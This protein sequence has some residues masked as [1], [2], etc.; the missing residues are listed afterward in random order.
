MILNEYNYN[1]SDTVA[2]ITDSNAP[3]DNST[4]S[5]DGADR[6]TSVSK[7]ADPQSFTRDDVGNRTGHTRYGETMSVSYTGGANTV[8]SRQ[9]SQSTT[10]YGYDAL[11]NLAQMTEG[12]VVHAYGYDG[13]NRQG[14]YYRDAE[15]QGDYRYNGPNQ[16]VWK[17]AEEAGGHFIYGPSGELLCDDNHTGISGFGPT[18]YYWAFGQLYGMTKSH[19]AGL[20]INDHLG[21]PESVQSIYPGPI[22]S[23]N[24]HAFDRTV[25]RLDDGLDG[26]FVGFPGQYHDR[27]SGLWYNGN[28]YYDP[29]NGR[30]T[31]SDP[32]GL[33]G[34]INTYAYA[35]GNPVSN[36]DPFG[37][38]T[39][40]IVWN[41]VGVG[42]SAF[43]HVSTNINGANYSF[44]PS[45]WDRSYP[46]SNAY[47]A[48]QQKFRGGNGTVLNLSPAQEAILAQCLKSSGGAYSATSNNCGT[49]IQSCLVK[50]G[51]NVGNSVLPANLLQALTNSAA[52]IGQISYPGPLVPSMPLVP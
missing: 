47:A 21:R 4:F 36:I 3:T 39:E 11:G 49:S 50:I 32:I 9:S 38:Y 42:S 13:F 5:Y 51:V 10:S 46:S 6:L 16:R 48:R 25:G 27:E 14:A 40:I 12:A 37:L 17:G 8:Q 34:G 15:L 22:W 35:N 19:A 30:Y 41:G 28:R 33:G 45:G 23:A 29:S 7:P 43:G 26:F 1:P 52:N 24:N 31:Q 20:V 2:A 18:T 44:T